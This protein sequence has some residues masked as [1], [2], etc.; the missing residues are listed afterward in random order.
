MTDAPG[1]VRVASQ[2]GWVTDTILGKMFRFS[3]DGSVSLKEVGRSSEP[4]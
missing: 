4:R 3:K 2:S 1:D